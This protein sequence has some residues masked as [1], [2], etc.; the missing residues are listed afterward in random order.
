MRRILAL[1]IVAWGIAL[2]TGCGRMDE[3]PASQATSLHSGDDAS[4]E[5]AQAHSWDDSS[6]AEGGPSGSDETDGDLEMRK[7]PAEPAREF[8]PERNNRPQSGTLTAGSFDDVQR[9]DD[10][11][12]FL[13]RVMQDNANARLP[14][15]SIGQPVIIHVRDTRG[16]PLGG[17]RVIVRQAKGQGGPLLDVCTGTDGRAM[18]LSG[19]DAAGVAGRGFLLTVESASDSVTQDVH[20]DQGPW[21]VTLD[22]TQARR[23]TQLDLALV[24]D[25]TGS[26]GDEL[27][28]LKSEIDDIA[29]TVARMYPN[30]D[31][32]YALILYRDDGD[33]YVTRTFD[34]TGSLDEF[35]QRLSEQSAAGGGDY[36]EAMHVALDHATGLDWHDRD[37]A[38]VL[39]LVGDAPPHDV[40]ADA[41][42]DAVGRLRASGVRIF[43][44]ASSGVALKAEFVMRAAAFLTMGQYLFLTD[45]SGV[46]N[47]HAKPHVPDY[48]VERLDRLMIRMI[49][50]ELSGRRLE[51]DEVIAIE[52]GQLEAPFGPGP[53]LPNQQQ[54]PNEF[55]SVPW[56]GAVWPTVPRW[57]LLLA[58]VLGVCV[59]DSLSS[60]HRS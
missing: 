21:Q 38:R 29:Q 57:G 3:S 17:A 47:P 43:P 27:E 59:F 46:G 15:L 50:S 24:I 55:S 45:H 11:R 54:R 41:A 35:R 22:D 7:T 53:V 40:F 6:G 23:P 1:C 19:Q 13:S 18:F 52:R 39:F 37:T 28:Y 2:L 16:K 5:A 48:Q 8:K 14:R 32:R 30:V 9:L 49:S 26:M 58:L 42:L 31:Q 56:R 33:Q 60:G 10:Y 25:T 36:P 12:D 44:I 4:T 34:F 51:P 20:L